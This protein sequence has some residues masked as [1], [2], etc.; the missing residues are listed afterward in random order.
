V[1]EKPRGDSLESR[2]EAEEALRERYRDERG[3]AY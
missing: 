1:T 2:E 3:R